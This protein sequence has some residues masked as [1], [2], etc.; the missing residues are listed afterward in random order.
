[1]KLIRTILI[2][3]LLIAVGYYTTRATLAQNHE[4]TQPETAP[5]QEDG[6]GRD[7]PLGENRLGTEPLGASPSEDDELTPDENEGTERLKGPIYDQ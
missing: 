3:M 2:G 1:M 5:D 6:T 7:N 4:T